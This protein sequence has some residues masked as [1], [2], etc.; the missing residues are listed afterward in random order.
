MLISG[1]LDIIFPAASREYAPLIED[2]WKDKAFQATYDRRNELHMPLPRI[3]NYFLDRVRSRS[4]ILITGSGSL[5]IL[6]GVSIVRGGLKSDRV[7]LVSV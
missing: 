5:K 4:V 1:N 7:M 6:F 3:A 2:I